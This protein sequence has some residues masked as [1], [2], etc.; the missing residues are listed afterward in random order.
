MLANGLDIITPESICVDPVPRVFSMIRF[1]PIRSATGTYDTAM[2]SPVSANI[3]TA[4]S[5]PSSLSHIVGD[6]GKPS[7]PDT[8]PTRSTAPIDKNTHPHDS[9]DVII[10]DELLTSPLHAMTNRYPS[11]MS[12]NMAKI[13]T[14]VRYRSA[15]STHMIAIHTSSM[16]DGI[17]RS[18]SG[19]GKL[20][21]LFLTTGDI[22]PVKILTTPS[23]PRC[24]RER[25]I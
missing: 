22:I 14:Q 23:I 18:V 20:S 9:E 1:L 12:T 3:V 24:I 8:L 25:V 11:N 4:L 16:Y 10:P 6:S 15:S 19:Y 17:W 7:L 5:Q 2:M 21:I 13:R